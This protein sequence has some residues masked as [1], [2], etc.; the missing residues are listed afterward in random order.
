VLL[1]PLHKHGP[2]PHCSGTR[3]AGRLP[4]FCHQSSTCPPGGDHTVRCTY[5][6]EYEQLPADDHLVCSAKGPP[7]RHHASPPHLLSSKLSLSTPLPHTFARCTYSQP[8]P[9]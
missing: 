8:R 9:S 1:T 7:P 2:L 5:K 4:T 6:G 3:T